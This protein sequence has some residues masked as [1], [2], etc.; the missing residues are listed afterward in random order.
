MKK[1]LSVACMSLLIASSISVSAQA[2]SRGNVAI[3]LDLSG[4]MNAELN[5]ESR[6]DV[7]IDALTETVGEIDGNAAVALYAFGNNFDNSPSSKAQSCEDINQLVDYGK[8]N[9]GAI[10]DVL[11]GL[12]AKGWTP[13][14]KSI[15][16]IGSDLAAFGDSEHHLI[17]LSDGEES[18]NGDPVAAVEELKANGVNVIVNTI[19]LDVDASTRSQLE[20]IA[21]AG[22]GQYFD[23]ADSGALSSGLVAAVETTQIEEQ[24]SADFSVE[25]R[26]VLGGSSFDDA[27]QLTMEDLDPDKTYQF[28]KNLSKAFMTYLFPEELEP[29]DKLTIGNVFDLYIDVREDGTISERDTSTYVDIKIFNKRKAAIVDERNIG[30]QFESYETEIELTEEMLEDSFLFIGQNEFNISEKTK[31][32]FEIEKAEAASTEAD[33]EEES[34]TEENSPEEL[35]GMDDLMNLL[36][37]EGSELDFAS[38]LG[39]GE[40]DIS[41]LLGALGGN[42]LQSSLE[43]NKEEI[44]RTPE[45]RAALDALGIEYKT[46]FLDK[47]TLG[48]KNMYLLVGGGIG[49]LLLVLLLVIITKKKK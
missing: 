37:G 21:T 35:Q 47:T 5:G 11:S 46:S 49:A 26:F 39:E 23:A 2:P 19:G 4:S 27:V 18:C 41:S 7:A 22:G 14:A 36:S 31:I 42:E 32:Y 38:L 13:L 1:L 15:S 44:A 34:E 17:I 40:G 29:G 6:R 10:K 33:E 25:D 20:A 30:Y 9:S 16:T 45:G 24:T 8:N 28:P 48:I 43:E 12:E 3:L